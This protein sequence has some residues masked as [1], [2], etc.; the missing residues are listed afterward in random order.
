[1]ARALGTACFSADA[2]TKRKEQRTVSAVNDPALYRR[3]RRF[4]SVNGALA[5]DLAGQVVADHVCG[6]QYSGVGGHEAFVT[7]AT[8]AP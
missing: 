6:R 8:R 1:M 2:M 4:V 5:I 3:P 7:G